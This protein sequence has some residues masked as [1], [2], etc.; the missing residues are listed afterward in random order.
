[1][2]DFSEIKKNP[3]SLISDSILNRFSDKHMVLQT[4]TSQIRNKK[5]EVRE[6]LNLTKTKSK[7][8]T[9]FRDLKE[10][11]RH[12]RQSHRVQ[13]WIR[14]KDFI[15]NINRDDSN[16]E[17]TNNSIFKWWIPQGQTKV[18]QESYGAIRELQNIK[19]LKLKVLKFKKQVTGQALFPSYSFKGNSPI[20]IHN[21]GKNTQNSTG[22]INIILPPR[23]NF[24]KNGKEITKIQLSARPNL[25]QN[26]KKILSR[27]TSLGT[28]RT[29]SKEK[30]FFVP[31]LNRQSRMLVKNETKNIQHNLSK[32]VATLEIA[33]SDENKD[34]YFARS[35]R[36]PVKEPTDNQIYRSYAV[37]K[38]EMKKLNFR[39]SQTSDQNGDRK[40]VFPKGFEKER[41]KS[42]IIQALNSRN[43]CSQLCIP[44]RMKKQWKTID[45]SQDNIPNI[46][47]V[48][49]LEKSYS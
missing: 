28:S 29:S 36:N 46:L 14:K 4:R 41:R 3:W 17:C 40:I 30:T 25:T 16:K 6:C 45:I 27:Q 31:L 7:R 48:S 21:M 43:D 19:K 10:P 26:V 34:F 1:M 22:N 49:D 15:S 5:K 37:R 18:R 24:P 35:S 32:S 39:M 11:A 38:S 8:K 13:S 12:Q 33:D 9:V 47:K 42:R 2:V 20:K 44:K 23:L